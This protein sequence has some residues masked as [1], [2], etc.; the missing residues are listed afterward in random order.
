MSRF[1]E[2]DETESTNIYLNDNPDLLKEHLLTVTAKSQT[3]GRGRIMPTNKLDLPQ[4][5]GPVSVLVHDEPRRYGRR[6]RR[7][8]SGW[9]SRPLADLGSRRAV[10]Q[11]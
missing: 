11:G 2:L 7:S 6:G 10:A 5:S 8:G 4:S 9:R 3:G 1:I